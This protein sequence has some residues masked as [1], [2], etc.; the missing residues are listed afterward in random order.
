MQ[1][2]NRRSISILR[3]ADFFLLV[4]ANI[5]TGDLSRKRKVSGFVL[6]ISED[7]CTHRASSD[8]PS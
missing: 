5:V 3:S 8:G 7:L 2:S 1:S 4:A 6:D